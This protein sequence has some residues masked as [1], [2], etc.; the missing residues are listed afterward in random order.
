M[1]EEWRVEVELGDEQHHL[2]LGERLRSLDLDDEA[3]KRLGERVIVTRDG[4]HM[5]LYAGSQPAAREAE[6]VA[7]ELIESE[8]LSGEARVTRWDDAQEAWTDASGAPGPAADVR[9]Y[10]QA[11]SEPDWEVRIDLPGVRET[12]ELAKRLEDEGL[13]VRR[14]WRH[15]LV[16]ADTEGEANGLAKR[17]SSELP[18]DAEVRVEPGGVPHPVFVF[19]GAH[20][21]G[22]ARDLGL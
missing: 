12:L 9:E 18:D 21:P 2:T 11:W 3:R 19:M 15:L 10:E 17:L 8:G 14:R 4:S 1:A 5:F 13:E 22:I 7:R 16:G 20:T 6:R